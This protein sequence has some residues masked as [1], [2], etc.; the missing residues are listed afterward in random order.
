MLLEANTIYTTKLGVDTIPTPNFTKSTIK[1]VYKLRQW[2]YEEAVRIN[3]LLSSDDMNCKFKFN[4]I[5]LSAFPKHPKQFTT[6]DIE[7]LNIM[8]FVN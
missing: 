2:M 4:L 1:T 8:L 3:T 5:L 6:A 7:T